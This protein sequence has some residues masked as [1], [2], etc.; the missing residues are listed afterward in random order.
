MLAEEY[1]R[2]TI[3]DDNDDIGKLREITE[4]IRQAE[5]KSFE[6]DVLRLGQK[7]LPE[8]I[9]VRDEKRQK[10]L[11]FLNADGNSFASRIKNFNKRV[12]N[13]K[14]SQFILIRD[15]RQGKIKSEVSAAQV[16]RLQHTANGEFI[17]L[18]KDNRVEFELLY[19]LITDIQN[20]DLDVDLETALQVFTEERRHWIVEKLLLEA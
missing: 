11:G 14:N 8:P 2:P 15:I 19:K 17:F 1:D 10:V 18:E 7:K 4:A 5:S 13:P 12:V 6:I 3:I 16:E 20:R 9:H